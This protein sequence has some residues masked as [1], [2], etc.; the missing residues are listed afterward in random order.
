MSGATTN[1]IDLTIYGGRN[2]RD[3]PAYPVD[4]AARLL[5][6]PRSTL[7]AWVFGSTWYDKKAN[8]IRR[9]QH[10][11]DPP[12]PIEDR[13]LSFV[14]LVEAHVLKSIRRVHLVQMDKVRDG[15]EHLKEFYPQTA[16]PLADIDLLAGGRDVFIERH[17][18]LLNV[19]MGKQLAMDFLVLYLRR[20]ERNVKG[21]AAKLFPFTVKPIRVG[22]KIIE[23]DA[24]KLIAIDPYVSFGRPIIN[25]TGIPTDA[26]AERFWGGDSID[27]LVK[28]F[29]R[30]QVEIEYAL[31]YENAQMARQQ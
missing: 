26:I 2:P 4:V 30:P 29:N 1:G 17:G 12:D 28:E 13:M 18:Q 6:L 3:L 25:G 16:H 21:F 27:V 7:V 5:L 14:N 11:L 31:R 10:L 24:E 19:T 20:I 9:F 8:R 22:R 23:Q 15:L